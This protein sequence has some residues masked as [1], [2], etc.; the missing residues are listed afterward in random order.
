M[1]HVAD[2]DYEVTFDRPYISAPYASYR[3]VLIRKLAIQI[4]VN[5]GAEAWEAPVYIA[6]PGYEPGL[7]PAEISQRPEPVQL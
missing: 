5:G 1:G 4:D 7:I 3:A 2:T 6:A